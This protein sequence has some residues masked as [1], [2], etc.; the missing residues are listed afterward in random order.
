MEHG[1]YTLSESA[2]DSLCHSILL[3]P[4]AYGVLPSNAMLIT[5]ECQGYTRG[6]FFGCNPLPAGI[7]LTFTTQRAKPEIVDRTSLRKV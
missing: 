5:S 2:I 3:R 7:P 1:S 6:Y 4:V